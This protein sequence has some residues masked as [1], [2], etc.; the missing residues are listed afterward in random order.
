MTARKNRRAR[1]KRI[2]FGKPV[3]AQT[4][5]GVPPTP[6][7]LRKLE[8]DV[9]SVL[10]EANGLT[11]VQRDAAMEIRGIHEAV[12]RGMFA[13]SAIGPAAARGGFNYGPRDFT[14]NMSSEELR[15]WETRYLP[16]SHELAVAIAAGMPGTRWL[17]LVTDVVVDNATPAAVEACYR[18]PAGSALR[19]LAE[20]LDRYG[21]R[22]NDRR[23]DR[24]RRPV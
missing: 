16:W 9:I 8:Q 3:Q 7:T 6:E 23:N 11:Q 21:A 17:Q 1:L 18:L 13:R 22:R 15:I 4:G 20:G 19:Y 12:G 24:R 14:Q 10:V 2:A 5:K